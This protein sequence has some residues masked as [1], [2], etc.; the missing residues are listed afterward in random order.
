[1]DVESSGAKSGGLKCG[2]DSVVRDDLR[3][4]HDDMDT[5]GKEFH[6]LGQSTAEEGRKRERIDEFMRI[7]RTAKMFDDEGVELLE[8]VC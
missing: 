4:A 6:V 3:V 8:H 1:M 7:G 5:V 2:F